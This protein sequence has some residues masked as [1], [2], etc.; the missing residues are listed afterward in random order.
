MFFWWYTAATFHVGEP[1][2]NPS[3]WAA[4]LTLQSQSW[5]CFTSLRP[6]T[7]GHWFAAS[8]HKRSVSLWKWLASSTVTARGFTVSFFTRRIGL[9]AAALD[10]STVLLCCCCVVLPAAV[11]SRR[12]VWHFIDPS[13]FSNL[14]PFPSLRSPSTRGLQSPQPG[15]YLR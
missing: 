6:E 15:S 4:H 7:W 8:W 3:A 11:K 2:E 14:S 10:S 1:V 13:N 12:K 9:P 5:I